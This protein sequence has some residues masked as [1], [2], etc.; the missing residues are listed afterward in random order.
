MSKGSFS[1]LCSRISLVEIAICG[2][3]VRLSEAIP[4]TGLVRRY[5]E[6]G[7][8]EGLSHQA[9]TLGSLREARAAIGLEIT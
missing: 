5:D 6:V 8:F 3:K 2:A 1:L 9:R 4:D 7:G